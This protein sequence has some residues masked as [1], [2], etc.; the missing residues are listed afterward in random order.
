MATATPILVYDCFQ[1]HGVVVRIN[2]GDG[3]LGPEISYPTGAWP[4]GIGVGDFNGDG[5]DDLAIANSFAYAESLSL[6]LNEG[7][8]TFET[9]ITYPLDAADSYVATGD[10][11]ADGHPDLAVTTNDAVSVL[12]SQC[13]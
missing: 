8:G 5:R 12:L 10:F 6:L 13:R 9:Q 11:N 3:S 7:G 2:K 4:L 1:D